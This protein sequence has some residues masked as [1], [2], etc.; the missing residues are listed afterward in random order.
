[1]CCSALERDRPPNDPDNFQPTDPWKSPDLSVRRRNLPHLE[2][3][4]ATY[5]VTFRCSP[6]FGLT[7]AARDVVIDVFR[8]SDAESIELEAV[9]VMPD[10]VHAIFRVTGSGRLSRVLRTVKGRSARLINKLLGR[11]GSSVWKDENFDHV[12]RHAAELKEKIAYMRQNPVKW[13]LVSR[14]EDYKWL[15]VR[16]TTG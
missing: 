8:R 5:F 11:S 4:G 16:R 10:H 1:M 9:V 14:P 12:I 2:V 3:P 6:G 7:P 13:G 15:F